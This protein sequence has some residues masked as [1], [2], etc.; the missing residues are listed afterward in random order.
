MAKKKKPI[1]KRSSTPVKRV[2]KKK[3]QVKRKVSKTGNSKP[4]KRSRQ[5]PKKRRS[6]KPKTRY[7]K[8]LHIRV[9]RKGTKAYKK[10][11][12]KH[13]HLRKC[14]KARS[15]AYKLYPELFPTYASTAAFC[16]YFLKQNKR[17]TLDNLEDAIKSFSQTIQRPDIPDYYFTPWFW[18]EADFRMDELRDYVVTNGIPNLWARSQLFSISPILINEYTYDSTLK[19]YVDWKNS[20][21]DAAR[22]GNRDYTELW[23]SLH[24]NVRKG[25][26]EIF[27]E[28][29]DNPGT[30][31]YVPKVPYDVLIKEEG[32][33]STGPIVAK[34]GEEK[35]KAKGKPK[36]KP[37]TT[38]PAAA[39]AK[40]IKKEID[41]LQQKRDAIYESIDLLIKEMIQYKNLGEQD[42]YAE[43]R[44]RLKELRK[45]IDSVNRQIVGLK[46]REQGGKI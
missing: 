32:K 30:S 17:L 26:W 24:Y 23:I 46:T 21:Q 33:E 19:A 37:K 18:F 35:P 31:G 25:R 5:L 11:L 8:K 1:K 45:E 4:K 14:S 43:T 3:P 36:P 2:I 42:L 9:P 22:E 38:P 15:L 29:E 27:I 6:Q 12:K 16:S 40:E 13:K 28:E 39:T 44:D 20:M 10:W 34:G 7:S 41:T